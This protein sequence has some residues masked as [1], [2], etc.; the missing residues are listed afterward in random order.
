MDWQPIETAPRDGTVV[1]LFSDDRA[2]E[3]NDY[4]YAGSWDAIG[5]CW[6][7]T[8]GD[9]AESERFGP[10]W[11]MPLPAPPPDH[12]LKAAERAYSE[13]RQAAWGKAV[14]SVEIRYAPPGPPKSLPD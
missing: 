5:D 8:H 14:G 1:I 6:C 3:G 13:V 12:V 2:G 7:T 11:W 4:P 9:D 10:H